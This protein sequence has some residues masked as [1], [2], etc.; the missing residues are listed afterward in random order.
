[1]KRVVGGTLAL[2]ATLI[3]HGGPAD[4]D[5]WKRSNIYVTAAVDIDAQ[6]KIKH[7]EF[8]P[9]K[10]SHG[11]DLQPALR[12]LAES[13]MSKW[14]F[15]PATANGHPAAAHTFVHA[16]FEFR[17]HGDDYDGR[18]VFVGN[19]P[20]IIDSKAPTYP[21]DMIKAGIQAKL[22]MLALVQSDGSLAEIK[23]ESAETTSRHSAAD[24]LRAA[25]IA[26]ASWHAEPEMVDGHPVV[27]LV[28]IPVRYFLRDSLNGRQYEA[29]LAQASD[30]PAPTRHIDS[31]DES[32]AL[33]SPV[34]MRPQS[35]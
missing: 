27:T 20:R 8:L 17:P 25:R 35:P 11:K 32:I 30:S 14:E 1:M 33:D 5:A 24:F 7:L 31:G 6:G 34:K 4:A 29:D 26:M 10:D 22:T 12:S 16:V 21:Q 28:R 23:L 19:G 3:A 18:M 15:I 9:F 2:M 13:T